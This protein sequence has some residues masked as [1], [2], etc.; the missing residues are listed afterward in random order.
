MIH[1][2]FENLDSRIVSG[3]TVYCLNDYEQ[4]A[5]R[6]KLGSFCVAKPKG[7]PSYSLDFSNRIVIDAIFEGIELTEDEFYNY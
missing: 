6:I 2:G 5:L 1:S 3:E 4:I 7:S